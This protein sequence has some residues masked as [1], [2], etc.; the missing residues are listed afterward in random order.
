MPWSLAAQATAP[1]DEP[2][3]IRI[4]QV[5]LTAYIQYDYVATPGE[6]PDPGGFRVRRARALLAGPL[7]A[8]IKWAISAEATGHPVLRD[9][10]IILDH[11]PAAT[12]RVGQLVMP[13]GLER[14]VATSNAME[15]TER[16]LPDLAPGRDGG[17]MVSNNEPLFGWFTYG[18]AIVNGTG[19]NIR[20]NNR[21]KDA[22]VRLGAS[23]AR[24][25]G[26]HLA[27]NASKGD[28]PDGMRTRTG[29]DLRY[30]NRSYHVGAEFLRQRTQ[31]G[32][33]TEDGWYGYGS[34][35]IYP[36]TP[37]RGLHHLEFAARYARRSGTGRV[38]MQ[39]WDVAA[40]Y[41]VHSRLRFMWDLILP[42][43]DREEGATLHA[44]ANIK[45]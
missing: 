18:A 40:N 10:Y 29:A 34:W 33:A 38:V 20:D 1:P 3:P 14:F 11:V 42:A 41:Y 24:V 2:A 16:S 15:F 6:N 39:Q 19:Q 4:G 27:V 17:L 21:A 37:R 12:L 7:A 31:D 22:M 26:V 9:A 28:Q 5:L 32:R 44:R 30:E 43:G 45:F 23:P 25:P 36:K 13:Y 8:G 35:R